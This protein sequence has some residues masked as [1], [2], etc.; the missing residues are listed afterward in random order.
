MTDKEKDE[1]GK[2][3]AGSVD[4]SVLQNLTFGPAWSD[5]KPQVKGG[6]RTE[7]KRPRPA[8]RSDGG[9]PDRRRGNR[10]NQRD[11]AASAEG[12]P[13]RERGVRHERRVPVFQPVVDVNFYPQD[14]PFRALCKAMRNTRR[15]YELFEIAQLILEKSER[16]VIVVNLRQDGSSP[17][18]SFFVSVPDGLPFPSEEEAVQHVMTKHLEKFFTVE[19]V[20]VDRPKGS[21][22]AVTRC[23]IT[24]ELLGPPN[25]HRYQHLLH[26]HHALRLPDV[27]YEKFQSRLE[28]VRDEALIEQWLTKMEKRTRYTPLEGGEALE[29]LDAVRHYLLGKQREQVVKE[30]TTCRFAGRAIA[31]LPS[32]LLRRSVEA[33]LEYQRRFP[34]RT[35]NNLRGRLRRMKFALYKKG[36]K[37]V[38]YVCAVRR[39]FRTTDEVFSDSIEA[40]IRCIEQNPG[41]RVADLPAKLLGIDVDKI[42]HPV[43]GEVNE[44]TAA[45]KQQ[46][47]TGEAPDSDEATLQGVP[48]A[49]LPEQSATADPAADD[50]TRLKHLMMELHWLVSEGYVTE[51]S[52]GRLQA[53][54]VIAAGAPTRPDKDFHGGDE[55]DDHFDEDAD[56]ASAGDSENI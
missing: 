51:F 56:L 43:R 6:G 5:D 32:G 21:F 20:T 42:V 39:R 37:G 14:E 13:Q 35:A 11:D 52:D 30:A 38:S 18:S 48:A 53:Q 12:F 34:L 3:A 45:V 17:F 44:P 22:Q 16:S 7:H 28:T 10:P 49:V 40:L 24:G 41:I 46:E 23:G 9:R 1:Q 33:E 54:P 47:T 26:E 27:S 4:L 50:S 25:Y 31:D 8:A 36:D 19:E 15:T 55:H 29:G 2:P